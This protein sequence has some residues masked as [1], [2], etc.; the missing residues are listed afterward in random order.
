MSP[1]AALINHSCDPNVA[2]VF[3]RPK[4][5]TLPGHLKAEKGPTEPVLQVVAIQ[6]IPAEEE[7]KN[8]CLLF[9]FA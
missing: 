6:D 5:S 9:S 4:L 7:V 8:T 2:V 1:V 3:P